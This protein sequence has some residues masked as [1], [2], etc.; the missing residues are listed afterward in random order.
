MRKLYPLF[1]TLFFFCFA[2]VEAQLPFDFELETFASGFSSPVDIANAG[3]DRL[4]IVERSGRIRII[5]GQGT[6]LSTPFLD[7]DQ[8][9][10]NAGNQSEQGLLGIEFHPNFTDNGYFFVHYIANN[11]DSVIARFTVD[12][13]DPNLADP[14]SEKRILVIG[15]P[16]T[17]H[18]GGSLKFGPDGFL[19]IGMGDGGSANDPGNRAQNPGTLLGKMLRIDIDNGDPYSIPMSN[20]YV[21][22]PDVLDEIWSIGLRNPWKFSFDSESGD[23]W[24]ADVGQGDWEEINIEPAGSPGGLNYGWR[25]FEGN[26]NFNTSGCAPMTEY[27]SPIIQ[28]NHLGFTH[29]SVTGGYVYRGTNAN[30]DDYNL[31]FYADYCSGT[32]WCSVDDGQSAEQ[33]EVD[34]FNNTFISSFGVDNA[35]EMYMADISSGR[36]FYLN[37][38]SCETDFEFQIAQG[39]DDSFSAPEGFDAYQ[40]FLDDEEIVGA[41][42]SSFLPTETGTYTVQITDENGCIFISEGFEFEALSVGSITGLEQL[43]LS[44][45]PV[46]D[47]LNLTLFSNKHIEATLELSNLAG[48]TFYSKQL[49]INGTSDLNID[50]HNFESGIYNLILRSKDETQVVRFLKL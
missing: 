39:S 43:K 3:D 19:Y 4:F 23:L 45:N 50:T 21:N 11:D 7:I 27:T 24:I 25:C 18:N 9:V 36:I 48:Q 42:N 29:C 41:T 37:L 46:D 15:Q 32:L 49:S 44:P 8:R 16:F 20:P 2:K 1:V 6:T 30:L 35:G 26:N 31:Y 47:V 28:Y 5:D 14:D 40:W 38:S 22:E 13:D 34:R 33:I 10:H 17:N 12:E